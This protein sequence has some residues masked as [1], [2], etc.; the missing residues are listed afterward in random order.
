M[1][2]HLLTLSS[3]FKNKTWK[4]LLPILLFFAL[5]N[6]SAFVF[7]F[8]LSLPTS[9]RVFYLTA[10]F[11][12][13]LFPFFM[14]FTIFFAFITFISMKLQLLLKLPRL[15]QH[16][17]NAES[18][19]NSRSTLKKVILYSLFQFK[20]G[21]RRH[22]GLVTFMLSFCMASLF[23]LGFSIGLCLIAASAISSISTAVATVFMKF[24]AKSFFE[25]LKK[26]SKHR[27]PL[28]F[29]SWASVT[30]IVLSFFLGFALYERSLRDRVILDFDSKTTCAAI[31]LKTNDGIIAS[32]PIRTSDKRHPKNN[33]FYIPHSSI[34]FIHNSNAREPECRD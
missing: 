22:R 13:L 5:S 21:W 29:L 18:K 30:S 17:E 15:Y 20:R 2:R 10:D 9:L 24:R 3:P 27:L 31:H 8:T 1:D 6:Y 33:T 32:T 26:F 16:K 28:T 11:S 12:I 7:G 34:K 23:L 19:I 14:Y 25:N 4:A